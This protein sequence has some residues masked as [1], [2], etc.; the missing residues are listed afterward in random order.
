MQNRNLVLFLTLSMAMLIAW[1]SFV[2]PR[3]LPPKKPAAALDA[4]KKDAGAASVA[5]SGQPGPEKTA[6]GETKKPEA[7]ASV[8]SSKG[9]VKAAAAA[10]DSK[11]AAAVV[12]AK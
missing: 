11:K 5:K 6:A 2:V 3:I 12:A 10:P 9:D 7:Q 1:N 4:A 8:A